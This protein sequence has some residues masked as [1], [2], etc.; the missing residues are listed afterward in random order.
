MQFL[1][2]VATIAYRDFTK[3]RRDRTRILA[4]FIFPF[5]FIG[6]LGGSL[7]S[8]LAQDA[9]YNFLTF[10]FTGVLGQVLFQSTAAGI[11]SLIEDRANDFSQEMFVSP[12]SRYTIIF[13]KIIGETS[14]S[15]AQ[16]FG[17]ILF[18][19]IIGVPLTLGNIIPVLPAMLAACLFG[20]AFGVLVLANLNSERSANQIFPFVIFPQFF[21]AGVFSPIKKLPLILDLLSRISPMRYAVDLIRAIYY[22]GVPE[23]DKIVLNSALYNLAIM[24]IVFT[25]FLT[26]GTYLFAHTEKNR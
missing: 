19:L 21:L 8:N 9:G 23:Y 2:S 3:F 22:R 24:T 10:I 11:I 17:V 1:N 16:G 13:G 25:I 12:V 26:L 20:G 18:A 15:L 14:I 6:V 4:T 5:L 7:Q